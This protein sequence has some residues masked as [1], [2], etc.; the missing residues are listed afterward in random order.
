MREFLKEQ[1]FSW[2]RPHVAANSE[3]NNIVSETARF[4]YGRIR[5]VVRGGGDNA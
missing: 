4:A 5:G 2:I 1:R 3:K